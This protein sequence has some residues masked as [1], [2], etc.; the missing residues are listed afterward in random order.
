[1]V[2]NML[3]SHDKQNNVVTLPTLLAVEQKYY[4]F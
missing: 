1:M 4:M 3:R 2:A